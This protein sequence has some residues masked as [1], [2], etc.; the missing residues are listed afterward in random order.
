MGLAWTRTAGFWPPLIVTNPTPDNC[1]IFCA[2]FVSAK[3]STLESGSVS[4]VSASVST[5]VSAG[6]TLL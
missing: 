6:F 1:E 5:G 4:D 3:S 2:R